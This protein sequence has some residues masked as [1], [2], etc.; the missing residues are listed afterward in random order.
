MQYKDN[1]S[2]IF[3]FSGQQPSNSLKQIVYVLHREKSRIANIKISWNLY[4]CFPVYPIVFSE[5]F[6]SP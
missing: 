1:N 6:F 4:S 3:Q 2:I 5:R